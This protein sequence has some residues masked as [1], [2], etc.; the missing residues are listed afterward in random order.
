MTSPRLC[1]HETVDAKRGKTANGSTGEFTL[2]A[3]W[4]ECE[5]TSAWNRLWARIFDE[6]IDVPAD[7]PG[8]K[9]ENPA[10]DANDQKP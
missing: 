8:T 1:S 9:T 10:S 4:R 6:A 7:D 5:R 3:E 2:R